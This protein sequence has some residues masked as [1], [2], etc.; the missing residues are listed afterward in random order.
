V[1]RQKLARLKEAGHPLYPNDFRPTHT[2]LQVHANFGAITDDK[3]A[4]SPEDLHIAGRVMR[5]RSFGLA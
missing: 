2:A 3:L 4:A 5:I 1:R